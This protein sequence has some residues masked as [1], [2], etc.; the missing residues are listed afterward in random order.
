M[1]TIFP[2]DPLPSVGQFS[3]LS[4]NF[5]LTR[6]KIDEQAYRYTGGDKIIDQLNFM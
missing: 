2:V 6:T 4:F 1:I 3:K 5:H